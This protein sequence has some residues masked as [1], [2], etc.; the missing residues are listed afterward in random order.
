VM[1]VAALL[2]LTKSLSLKL[3][4]A[5]VAVL[6]IIAGLDFLFQY[7]TWYNKQKMSLREMKEEFKQSEG[8]PHIKAKIRQLRQERTRKRMMAA[9][10]KASV[11]ITNPTHYAVALQYER[12]MTAPVCVA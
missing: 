11:V 8:D 7:R 10:P 3:I 12:G 5:V 6:A 9:V 4:G 1:D 2:D